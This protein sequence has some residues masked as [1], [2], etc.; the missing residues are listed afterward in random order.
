MRLMTVSMSIPVRGVA[1]L[2]ETCQVRDDRCGINCRQHVRFNSD[3]IERAA[4][5][6]GDP[7]EVAS[8]SEGRT[9]DTIEGSLE[10]AEGDPNDTS[11][12]Q[13]GDVA[14]FF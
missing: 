7:C 10:N 9:A 8:N 1:E 3:P 2:G 5:R 13:D 14:F 4:G 12:Q 6:R 11:P